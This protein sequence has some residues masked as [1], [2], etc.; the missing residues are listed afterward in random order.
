MLGFTPADFDDMATPVWRDNW[1]S[2]VI[3]DQVST[4]WRV[5]S[6]S[7]IGLDYNVLPQVFRL[8]G[9]SRKDQPR[10]FSD[11]RV[12]ENEALNILNAKDS[13]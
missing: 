3:F 10:L 1:L 13:P 8:N 7:V 4:Q 9:V 5:G 6:H 12:M 2:L 11:I